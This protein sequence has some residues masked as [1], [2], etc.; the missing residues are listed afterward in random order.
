MQKFRK[1]KLNFD[2]LISLIRNNIFG[3]NKLFNVKLVQ[4]M[5]GFMTE[6]QTYYIEYI[7]V[8]SFLPWRPTYAVERDFIARINYFYF[9]FK[10]SQLLINIW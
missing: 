10:M 4:N 9:W 3:A 1:I 5:V 7:S 8:M 6:W 2:G